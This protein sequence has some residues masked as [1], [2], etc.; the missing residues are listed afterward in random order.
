LTRN[1]S[2]LATTGY[3]PPVIMYAETAFVLINSSAHLNHRYG[4]VDTNMLQE[5][6]SSVETENIVVCLHHH[7]IP[8]NE[9]SCV[10]NS[11]ELMRVCDENNVKVILHGHRHMA[12]LMAIGNSNILVC[13]AGSMGLDIRTAG[14]TNQFNL[15]ANNEDW[16]QI[17]VTAFRYL[18]D[19]ISGGEPKEFIEE[20]VCYEK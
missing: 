13:G 20:I 3:A 1:E 17:N 14:Y 7:L 18:A 16:S 5:T 9:Y 11:Y 12:G 10:K 15:I 2:M 8:N 19:K 4:M 6:L